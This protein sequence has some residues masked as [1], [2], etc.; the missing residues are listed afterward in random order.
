M[1]V[2]DNNGNREALMLPSTSTTF[3]LGKTKKAGH[4][5]KHVMA[6]FFTFASIAHLVVFRLDQ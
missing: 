5:E 1:K 4:C 6:S 3:I 2:F